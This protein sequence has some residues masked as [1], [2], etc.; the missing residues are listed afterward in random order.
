MTLFH[1]LNQ[2]KSDCILGLS[3]LAINQNALCEQ[4]GIPSENVFLA[5]R[6]SGM[7]MQ[8]VRVENSSIK[9]TALIRLLKTPANQS[10][11][12]IIYVLY[13]NESDHLAQYLRTCGLDADSYHSGV[14]ANQKKDIKSRFSKNKLKII[15]TPTAFRQSNFDLQVSGIIHYITWPLPTQKPSGETINL[16]SI[17]LL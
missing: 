4:S 5:K 7:D 6:L 10:L 15:V 13:Q 2:L 1:L 16:K 8:V 12:W 9:D 11:N 14:Q 3:E 17:I